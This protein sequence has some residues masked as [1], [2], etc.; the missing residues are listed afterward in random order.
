MSSNRGVV[1]F[2]VFELDLAAD[3]LRKRGATT[4]LR[5][6]PLKVLRLL[7]ERP[8]DVVTRAELRHAC[9][10][11]RRSSSSTWASAPPCGG[12]AGR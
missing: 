1:R 11:S 2:G 3:E 9:G 7:V 6:Q 12:C 4:H 8:G 5:G 10:T